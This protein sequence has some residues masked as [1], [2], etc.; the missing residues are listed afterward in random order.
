MY[1]VLLF[2]S[3]LFHKHVQEKSYTL[4]CLGDSYTIGESVTAEERFPD[5]AITILKKENIRFKDPII[6]ARTGWTSQNLISA[7]DKANFENTFD[8]VTVLIGVNDQFQGVDTS[9]YAANFERLIKNAIQCTAGMK[10]HVIVFSIPDYS[11]SP[12]AA[13]LRK[14]QE[15]ISN[16]IDAFNT[17]NRKIAEEY[18]V[19]Y[20]DINPI[21][22]KAK[23]DITL[24]APDGL[25][26]SGKMYGIWAEF[27]AKEI[28]IQIE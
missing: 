9:E 26:T 16:E 6:V 28:R 22:K 27:L 11:V 14:P 2:F 17:V 4:L 20:I 12:F 19:Q 24:L 5:Q 3:I 23:T 15:L 13:H 7:I 1:V 10:D 8:Y 21:S 25:H 18:Q